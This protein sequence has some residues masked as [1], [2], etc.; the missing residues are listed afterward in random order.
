MHMYD[1]D[2]VRNKNPKSL[3]VVKPSLCVCMCVCM[4]V[5]ACV[6][7]HVCV[8]AR[9]CTQVCTLIDMYDL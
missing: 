6:R 5:C 2:S 9:V 3:Q 7:V 8:C 4:C 1:F